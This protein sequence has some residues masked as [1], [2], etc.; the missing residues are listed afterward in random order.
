MID[1]ASL[2]T[3]ELAIYNKFILKLPDTIIDSDYAIFIALLSVMIRGVDQ[4]IEDLYRQFDVNTADEVY[5][6]EL[7]RLVG[8]DWMEML[9][10][11]SNRARLAHH[12]YRR[13]YRGTLDSIKNLIRASIDEES[14]YSNAEN[15]QIRIIENGHIITVELPEE[16]LIFRLDIEEVR[17]AGTM[18]RFL[19]RIVLKYALLNL[20]VLDG[21]NQYTIQ[22]QNARAA[23]ETIDADPFDNPELQYLPKFCRDRTGNKRTLRT[24][25][26]RPIVM[27]TT[28]PF[29][30]NDTYI[31]VT[32]VTDPA[33]GSGGS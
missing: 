14:F 24:I 26:N 9:S 27:M 25:W 18:I 31:E 19:Y 17:P 13:K 12:G 22:I 28:T 30:I 16:F 5:L 32:V 8:Y 33:P 1:V 21:M 23:K 6:R 20:A 7:A 2:T 29:Y 10:L 15:N 3:E 4:N 11:A